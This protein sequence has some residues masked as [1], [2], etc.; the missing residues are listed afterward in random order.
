MDERLDDVYRSGEVGEEGD[1]DTH[2]FRKSLQI[3]RALY[4]F[5]HALRQPASV[6]LPFS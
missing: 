5:S 3:A 4:M 2:W 6:R 1:T